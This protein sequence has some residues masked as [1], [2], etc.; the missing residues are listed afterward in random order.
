L[1]RHS[2]RRDSAGWFAIL[3]DE[4]R[5]LLASLSGIVHHPTGC[6]LGPR[7]HLPILCGLLLCRATVACLWGADLPVNRRKRGVGDRVR[8]GCERT[9]SGLLGRYRAIC[10]RLGGALLLR[11]GRLGAISVPVSLPLLWGSAHRGIGRRVV[12]LDGAGA[13]LLWGSVIHHPAICLV[14]SR[15]HLPIWSLRGGVHPPILVLCNGNHLPALLVGGRNAWPL[16]HGRGGTHPP[17]LVLWSSNHRPI[18]LLGSGG[19]P[20]ILVRRSMI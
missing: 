4:A 18:G 19:N 11:W 16:G 20:P 2:R 3:L 5:R 13:L 8:G 1:N 12:L 9:V 15:K 7:R 14:R 17:I 10:R 6:L